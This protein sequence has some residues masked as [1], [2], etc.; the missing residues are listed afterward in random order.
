MSR[1]ARPH[2]ARYLRQAYAYAARNS[3]V[4]ALLW[5][6]VDDWNP[7]GDADKAGNGVYM[8]VRTYKGQPKPSW[9]AFAQR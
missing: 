8:G 4:K 1:S 2:Q 9:Y 5:F 6:L 3:Q 7:T